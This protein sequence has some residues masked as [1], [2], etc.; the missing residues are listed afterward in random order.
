MHG[1]EG[2]VFQDFRENHDVKCFVPIR[3]GSFEV[4]PIHMKA[5]LTHSKRLPKRYPRGWSAFVRRRRDNDVGEPENFM[6]AGT[7]LP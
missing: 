2:K 6:K 1:I 3:E 7:R 5:K 4:E